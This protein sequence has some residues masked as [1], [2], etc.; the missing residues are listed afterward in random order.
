MIS[1]KYFKALLLTLALLTGIITLPAKAEEPIK[2]S[3]ALI[4]ELVPVTGDRAQVDLRITFALNSARLTP[5]AMLQLDELGKAL[6]SSTLE[7]LDI[8]IYGHTD[9]SGRAPMN[10]ALSK[11]RARSAYDYLIGNFSLAGRKIIHDGFGE[12]APIN[13]INSYAAENRRVEI[14]TSK[15]I[16]TVPSLPIN[17][18]TQV[19]N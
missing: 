12:T 14:I 17:G 2:D 15:P 7:N 3:R 16:L 5:N 11:A 10:M 9:A 19:I 1:V 13:P 18:A 4:G 6:K 8:A